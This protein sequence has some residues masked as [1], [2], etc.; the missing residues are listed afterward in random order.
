[1]QNFGGRKLLDRHSLGFLRHH[2][3]E[4]VELLSEEWVVRVGVAQS[5]LRIVF[6]ARLWY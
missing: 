5:S 1:M 4:N 2:W 6:I 3:S